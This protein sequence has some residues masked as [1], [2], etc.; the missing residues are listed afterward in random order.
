MFTS[1]K[2]IPPDVVIAWGC[3]P[4]QS[5]ERSWVIELLRPYLLHEVLCNKPE[6]EFWLPDNALLMLVE[7]GRY[8][9]HRVFTDE[10]TNF[11]LALRKNRIDKLSKAKN[12]IIWHIG[13]EEGVDGDL[14]YPSLPEHIRVFRS[15]PYTK[16]DKFKRVS[17]IP[18]GPTRW[19]LVDIPW[20]Y[21]SDRK[22]PWAF[23]G[24][25]WDKT[26]RKSAV[27]TFSQFMPDGFL[28]EGIKFGEGVKRNVYTSIICDACF[29]LC[30]EGNYHQETFR[31]YESLELGSIPLCLND[32]DYYDKLFSE[33]PPLP[34]FSTWEM[35]AGFA[36]DLLLDLKQLDELQLK[37]YHWWLNQRHYH[38]SK[39][40]QH[41]NSSLFTFLLII[42]ILT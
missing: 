8:T 25:I 2:S 26:S 28:N 29:C 32:Y 21:A 34:S 20:R 17:N 39:F 10:Q 12:I 38:S 18:I 1:F 31:F 40:S 27:N 15:F 30:P 6:F 22:Y 36:S 41:I 4:N 23:I 14:L 3:D 16:F 11:Y 13:D 19:T 33:R 5:W 24:T 9:D 35:A 37:F 7:S 42:V